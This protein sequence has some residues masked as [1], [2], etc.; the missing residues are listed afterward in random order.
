MPFYTTHSVNVK[1]A[2]GSNS[3]FKLQQD[4]VS[5]PGTPAKL[6]ITKEPKIKFSFSN[7]HG[8][9]LLSYW[10]ELTLLNGFGGDILATF[11]ANE[12]S[13]FRLLIEIN[14]VEVFRGILDS[15][16]NDKPVSDDT[17]TYFELN[18][19][20]HSGFA[21]SDSVSIQSIL[22]AINSSSNTLHTYQTSDN[23]G[24]LP[25][26]DLWHEFIFQ[27]ICG[28][29]TNDIL[30]AHDW[31]ASGARA[32]VSCQ[33]R[34][35]Q[36][37]PYFLNELVSRDVWYKA[38]CRSFSLAVGYSWS[39]GKP[40]I[41]DVRKGNAG[42]YSAIPLTKVSS[43]LRTQGSAVTISEQTVINWIDNNPK[44]PYRP[45]YVSVAVVDKDNVLKVVASNDDAN[46]VGEGVLTVEIKFNPEVD[47]E[48][49][50]GGQKYGISVLGSVDYEPATTFKGWNSDNPTSV[51]S[52]FHANA[53][54]QGSFSR[55]L[56]TDE[57]VNFKGELNNIVDPM[58]PVK[59]GDYR[60]RISK[61]ELFTLQMK[62]KVQDAVLLS[63]DSTNL[64]IT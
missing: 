57:N 39:V 47:A 29:T 24:S 20:F 48:T 36:I 35:L 58:L 17:S 45:Q 21:N 43:G 44:A 63:D 53:Y 13:D 12:Q 2:K 7:D 60:Y 5:D 18:A 64:T 6:S 28:Y 49:T 3:V 61:G 50:V 40:I 9:G 46:A 11:L 22:T 4:L 23:L 52:L 16:W 19:V 25:F 56:P 62:T 59:L 38:L 33:L 15:Q 51:E 27:E 31:I 34:E 42:N 8:E 10:V 30:I 1:N 55:A 37:N 54:A 32:A 41:Q 26:A 14:S